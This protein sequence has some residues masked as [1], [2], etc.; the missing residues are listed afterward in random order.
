MSEDNLR[1][2]YSVTTYITREA[3]L[4]S[5]ITKH[6]PLSHLDDFSQRELAAAERFIKALRDILGENNS[7]QVSGHSQIIRN[8]LIRIYHHQDLIP[9]APAIKKML[10]IRANCYMDEKTIRNIL[11][12]CLPSKK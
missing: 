9:K 1:S 11:A 4:N 5:K 12:R 7:I 8:L 6:I 10:E 3:L 2:F